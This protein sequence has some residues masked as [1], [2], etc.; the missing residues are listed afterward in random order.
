MDIQA[1]TV[2]INNVEYIRKDSV[3]DAVATNYSDWSIVRADSGVFFG[4]VKSFTPKECSGHAVAVIENARQIHYFVVNGLNHLDIAV[5][6]LLP[7]SKVTSEIKEI[8]V[9]DARSKCACTE[10]AS[11]SIQ[12]FAPWRK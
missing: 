5:N 3:K 11:K 2:T 8:T 6:G 10:A 1:D 9:T 7:G 12:G 4:Q